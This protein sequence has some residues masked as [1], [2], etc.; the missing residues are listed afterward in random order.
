MAD[1]PCW[2]RIILKGVNDL[3]ELGRRTGLPCDGLEEAVS[4]H[5]LRINQYFWGLIERPDDPIARQVIPS[6]LEAEDLLG[7]E[8]P[9]KEEHYSPVPNCTHRYPDRVLF[10]VS[11]QCA[12]YCRFCNRRRKVG[13]PNIVTKETIDAGLSYIEQTPSVRE[14]IL[15]G[16]DPF[17]LRDEPIE[18]I[19][20]A[21]KAIRHVKT[22]R[23]G[24]RV[25]CALPQR[26]T[27]RLLGIL[28]RYRPL[29][30]NIHFNHPREITPE[31]ER[32]LGNLR[33]SGISLGSQTVLLKGINDD[34]ETLKE[35]FLGLL[36]LGVRPY[37]LFQA[38]MVKGTR[39]FWTHPLKGAELMKGLWG[40]ISGMAIP[41][42]AIDLPNGGGKVLLAPECIRSMDEKGIGIQ[43]FEGKIIR[44]E[45]FWEG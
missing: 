19:L 26:I 3:K 29:Y 22:V 44:I 4:R 40:K 2:E 10:L 41:H 11:N 24:T 20:K 36:G 16:G 9:L 32:A 43:N 38:D 34:V 5:P 37:Y 30:V 31:V 6:S 13:R 45:R 15:S 39:H 18:Y 7:E 28:R 1:R 27:K 35:L 17:M 33:D 12:I 8:D 14:V 21:L 23:I 42:V 25:P